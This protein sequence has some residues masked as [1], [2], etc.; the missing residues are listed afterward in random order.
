MKWTDCEDAWRRQPAGAATAAEI[1]ALQAGFEATS[2]QLARRRRLRA[3]IE[4]SMGPLVSIA[5][6]CRWLFTGRGGLATL[7]AIL[8]ILG[9]FTASWLMCRRSRQA[10]S[11]DAPLL[12]KVEADIAGLES[13]R[14]LL[15]TM[16]TSVYG[17]VIAVVLLVPF[18]IYIAIDRRADSFAVAF[19]IYFSATLIA[20]WLL[21][22]R[23][24]RRRIDP[25]LD[26]LEKLREALR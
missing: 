11:Q 26:E 7:V 8:L 9:G 13:D 12:V 19:S 24:V 3:A 17:A 5:I 20:G 23:E 1:A 4:M 2:R 22:R 16:R 10:P 18:V 15:V 14:R 25:R 21:N 6:A